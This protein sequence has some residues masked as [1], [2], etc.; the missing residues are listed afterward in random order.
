MFPDENH[1]ATNAADFQPRLNAS[2]KSI[3]LKL[4]SLFRMLERASLAHLLHI[5]MPI[6]CCDSCISCGCKTAKGESSCGSCSRHYPFAQGALITSWKRYLPAFS[7]SIFNPVSNLSS[8]NLSPNSC[9]FH[10]WPR[11]QF[12]ENL[13]KP[14]PVF[15]AQSYVCEQ[16][17]PFAVPLKPL[18]DGPH[19]P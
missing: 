2:V 19:L 12:V 4:F 15:V 11:V 5:L 8:Q 3:P 16:S 14:G 13:H 7:H 9:L 18:K 17:I 1:S 10:N 6:L